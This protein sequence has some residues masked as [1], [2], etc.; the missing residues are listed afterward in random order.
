MVNKDGFTSHLYRLTQ[1][2]NSIWHIPFE[3]RHLSSSLRSSVPR[4]PCLYLGD[5]IDTCIKE[6]GNS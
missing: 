1:F 3:I 5:S 6:I 4:L 2:K